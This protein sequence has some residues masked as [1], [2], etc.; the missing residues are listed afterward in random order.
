MNMFRKII[1]YAL[2]AL[3][4]LGLQ[5]GCSSTK[6]LARTQQ[7]RSAPASAPAVLTKGGVLY[8]LDHYRL[9]DSQLLAVGTQEKDG[10]LQPFK[11]HLALADIDYVQAN[12]HWG[13]GKTL[14]AAGVVVI[15]SAIAISSLGNGNDGVSVQEFHGFYYPPSYPG[16]CPLIYSH[17]GGRYHLESESFAGAVFK[18]AERASF[19][20][21][22]RL[23]PVKGQYRLKLANESDETEYVNEIKLLVVDAPPGVTVLP[24][25]K[26]NFHTLAR[27]VYPLRCVDGENRDVLSAVREKDDRWWESELA[28]K[29]LRSDE[30]LRDG[31]VLEFEKPPVARTAKLVVHGIN[32]T[33][34]VFAFEQLFK[35]KGDGQLR[36]YQRLERDPAERAKMIAWMKREGMLHVKV[37]QNGEWVEQTALL[38]VGPRISKDQIAVLDL[39]QISGD[40]VK[41]KLESATDL[42]RI[43]CVYLDYSADL[44]VEIAEINPAN[45]VD[46]LGKDVTDLL[47]RDD[48]RYYVTMK[49][50]HAELTFDEAPARA[51]LQRHYAV[52]AK[53][54]YHHWFNTQ[55]EDQAALLDRVLTEPLFGSRTFMPVWKALKG[56]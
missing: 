11:G 51:G 44:P 29:D 14:L 20:N 13:A 38:D 2:V 17:D 46:E 42:W 1:P 15:F 36:W 35:L 52:R 10:K 43:N 8:R 54:Y 32:T 41:L 21:L 22:E 24:N 26:G 19:D 16:S 34:G 48:D 18:G 28:A 25:A 37:W 30:K 27:P 7:P 40:T 45:A 55:G 6:E 9:A 33:L 39:S 3:T 23:Q 47:R 53:G 5:S 31:L 12:D 49:G 50:Q 4:F 56:Q